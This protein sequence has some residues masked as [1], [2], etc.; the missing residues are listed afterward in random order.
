MCLNE[1]WISSRTTNIIEC[2]N[3]EFKRRTKTMEIIV[4]ENACYV[5]LDFTSLKMETHW[6]S[7][8]IGKVRKNLPFSS[9]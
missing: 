6:R 3:K 1:K 2:L 4:G 7:N 9:N 8:P 5:L